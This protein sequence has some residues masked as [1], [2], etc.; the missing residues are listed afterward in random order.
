M[1]PL[2]EWLPD[3]PIITGPNLRSAKNVIPKLQSYGPFKGLSA[4]SVAL[5][6]RPRGAGTFR[7][8]ATTVHVYS[9][10]ETTLNELQTDGTWTDRSRLSGG[11]YATAET[12]TWNFAQFG[13]KVLGT[14]FNDA[15]Q[16]ATMSTG[17][18]FADASGTPPNA[19]H[20]ATFGDF[21][22]LGYT[23]NSPFEIYWSGIDDA[24]SWT[25][26]TNQSDFQR[27]P[28]GG[29]VQGMAGTDIL[30][31]FQQTKIRRMQYVG[32]PVIMQI[33]EL[34][35]ARGCLEAGSIAEQGRMVFFLSDDGFYM[36]RGGEPEPI[37]TNKVTNWFFDD[38]KRDSL[39]RM[40][41]A[42]EPQET[43]V[44]WSYTSTASANDTPDTIIIYNWTSQRWSYARITLDLL[45][46][47]LGLGYTL[48]D[49][50]TL[51]TNIDTFSIP[52][53][54]PLLTGGTPRFGAFATD[55]TY[56]IFAGSTLASE[57]ET[58][59]FEFSPK[60]RAYV[61]GVEPM[62]DSES[63]TVATSGRERLGATV[64]YATAQALET[65]GHASADSSGRYHRF[66]LATPAADSWNDYTGI[67]VLAEDDGEA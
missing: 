62:V 58:A 67:E 25:A 63:A 53:D 6:T 14:N 29:L 39:Y 37:S 51:T 22:V 57:I 61:H 5:S 26:G 12:N 13:D 16:I 41:S 66:K 52:L 40:T 47:S 24:E 8:V 2:G 44:Y 23:D 31:I 36:L 49:L 17:S 19:K 54:D 59:D 56:N 48:E 32:P 11:A 27:F 50:D 15:V 30:Y 9:G 42:V 20:I 45:F 43:L 18:Q 34:S 3:Q 4:V 64:S 60:R 33:D 21:V 35:T 46:P 28:D 10:D 65:T 7:D 1:I 55:F 38:V